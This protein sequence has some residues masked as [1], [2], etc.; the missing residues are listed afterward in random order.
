MGLELSKIRKLIVEQRKKQI[1]Q[2]AIYHQLRIKFHAQTE[3]TSCYY[4]PVTDFFAF[5][6]NFHDVVAK[7]ALDAGNE[8]FHL[9]QQPP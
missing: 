4:Q 1:I 5:V 6:K 3:I 8:K 9:T 2:R 7:L